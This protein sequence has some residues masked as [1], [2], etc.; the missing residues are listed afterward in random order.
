VYDCAGGALQLTLLPKATHVLQ[1][2]LDGKVVIRQHISGEVW[3]GS[4]RVPPSPGQRNCTFSI[5]GQSLLGSTR[6]DFA[7]P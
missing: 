4:V 6:I 5:V 7:R 1:I 3:H 2:L